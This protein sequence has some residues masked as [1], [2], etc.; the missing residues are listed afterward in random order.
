M[1][2]F[3][4]II[5]IIDLVI[6]HSLLAYLTYR[7]FV[8]SAPV[9]VVIP[10]VTPQPTLQIITPFPSPTISLPAPTKIQIKPTKRVTYVSI[11]ASGSTLANVWTDLPGTEFYF[12]SADF[13]NLTEVNFE[14]NIKLF[15]GNGLAFVRIYDI[16]HGIG[17]PGSEIQ[18]NSQAGTAVVSGRITFWTG[19]NMFRVQA[20]S[21]TADTTIFNG[22]R[23]KIT[24]VD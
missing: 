22:G 23:L 21:L 12:D 19:K 8:T 17:V 11:P 5:L 7:S 14:A 13:P 18:S 24:T 16:A 10:S 3:L 15:N 4:V 20:K 9:A 1:S 2:K 6:M